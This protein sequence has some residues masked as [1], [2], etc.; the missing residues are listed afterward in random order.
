MQ[1]AAG[2]T[3]RELKGGRGRGWAVAAMALASGLIGVVLSRLVFPH[4]SINNDEAI[5]RIQAEALA[6]GHLFSPTLGLP[7]AF[8]PWLAAVSGDHYVFKYTPVV[9]AMIALSLLVVGGPELHLAV[10]ASATVVMTYLL[11]REVLEDP[12]AALVAAALV[13]GSPLVLLHSGLLLSYLPNLLLLETFAWALFRG[14]SRGRSGLLALSGL[15]IGLAFFARAYDAVV[16]ALPI[17]IWVLLGRSSRR[18]NLRQATAFALPAVAVLGCFLA[19]NTAATGSPFHVT[20]SLLDSKDAIGFGERRLY[21]TAGTRQF[22]PLDGVEGV[23]RHG[24]LLGIWVAGG[25]ILAV[26]AAATVIRRRVR[27]PAAAVVAA[28]ALCPVSY[29]VFWGPWTATVDW[30]GA[31]YV[32]PFYFFPVLLPLALA[33]G[34]GLV[35]LFRRHRRAGLAT[36]FAVVA[37]TGLT[38]AAVLDANLAFSR[39][40]RSLATLVSGRAPQ[41][42]V[43]ATM[44]APFLM[45]PSAVISNRWDVTGPI[46]YAVASGEADLDVVHRMPERTPYRLVYRDTFLDPDQTMRARLDELRLL[47]GENLVVQVAAGPSPLPGPERPRLAVSAFGVTCEYTL[48]GAPEQRVVIDAQGAQLEGRQAESTYPDATPDGLEISLL[49]P[50]GIPAERPAP[51]TERLPLRRTGT[52]VELLAPAG[53]TWTVGGGPDPRPRLTT[54]AGDPR[55]LATAAP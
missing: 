17:L 28:G 51:A 15:A 46:V 24:A 33:G 35:D 36:S 53:P 25:A 5:N 43:F 10:I 40:N 41:Q 3:G 32:G 31:R 7:D 11:A 44:P 8:R 21:P 4:L 16:F 48:D 29:L 27:G 13:A 1:E 47:R 49:G 26:L 52:A 9:P 20:F 12:T 14:L 54:V 37:L 42:L 2:S 45:H 18:P 38:L 22:G 23:V 19:F 55:L 34:R 30:G 6:R 50:G 39:Q